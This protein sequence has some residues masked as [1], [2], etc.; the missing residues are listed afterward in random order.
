[1]RIRL[2]DH[3]DTKSIQELA[4]SEA[5][6]KT[7]NVPHPYPENGGQEFVKFALTR[8][9]SGI[10]MPFAIEENNRLIGLVTIND[11]K[12]IPSIDYWVGFP[13]W[14]KGFA[15]QAV[16]ETL[17]YGFNYLNI[18]LFESKALKEN[19]QS[20]KVL[21]KNGFS[22]ISEQPYT[23]PKNSHLGKTLYVY[24]IQRGS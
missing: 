16:K 6:S 8:Y 11:I 10:S 17:D 21:L 14:G 5:V 1:M 15:T 18:E 13:F 20:H 12:N 3:R 23:G 4:S 24:Q 7:T 19:H 22:K 9:G 2:I